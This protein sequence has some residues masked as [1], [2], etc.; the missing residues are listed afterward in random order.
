MTP[1]P[2]PAL[3]KQA[4]GWGYIECFVVVSLFLLSSLF[5]LLL[6]L[7]TF[8]LYS[9]LTT[10]EISKR[11]STVIMRAMVKV[12]MIMRVKRMKIMN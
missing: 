2:T 6:F 1:T 5:S 7:L 11:V 8:Y 12:K 9:N 3:A 4:Q 10:L